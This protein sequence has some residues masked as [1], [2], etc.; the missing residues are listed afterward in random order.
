[1]VRTCAP[2]RQAH[3]G[4]RPLP[5][6]GRQQLLPVHVCVQ[7]A[8]LCEPPRSLRLRVPQQVSISDGRGSR[9][10]LTK[11]C[12]PPGSVP[13]TCVASSSMLKLAATTLVLPRSS[14]RHDFFRFWTSCTILTTIVD[15]RPSTSR[16]TAPSTSTRTARGSG[17]SSRAATRTSRPR[18]RTTTST[19]PSLR[20]AT[21]PR[22]TPPSSSPRCTSV[23]TSWTCDRLGG[24]R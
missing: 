3:L 15:S 14:T 17:R 10:L 1:M 18:T 6:S 7:R 8:L 23:N 24:V 4:F 9:P 21:A 12:S 5:H 22:A 2:W 20:S 19:S 13:S 16:R 11:E